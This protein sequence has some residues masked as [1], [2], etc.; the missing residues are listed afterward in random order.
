M[1]KKIFYGVFFLYFL[2]TGCAEN[3]GGE[4]Q[5]SLNEQPAQDAMQIVFEENILFDSALVSYFIDSAPKAIKQL[6]QCLKQPEIFHGL[7]PNRLLLYGPPG[8]G[9][10]TLAKV[11]AQEAGIYY[12]VI[13]GSSIATEYKNSGAMNLSRIF[14]T[15]CA[16]PANQ[17]IIV[18]IDEINYHIGKH[19]DSN[20]YDANT[21]P[22][23]WLIL[24]ECAKKYPNIFIIG[25]ANDIADMP[26]QLKSRFSH[27][28][29][30]LN[31]PNSIAQR[32]KIISFY[33]KNYIHSCSGNYINDLAE[34]TWG[35][36]PREL[37]NLVKKAYI[38]SLLRN[39]RVCCIRSS[40]C[41]AVLRS[42]IKNKKLFEKSSKIDYK[43]IIIKG[44]EYTGLCL[45]I[46][47]NM[48]L[49]T[50]SYLKIQILE[51][52]LS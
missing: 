14:S 45:G 4:L 30:P 48:Y 15:I 50:Q 52:Q 3:S 26:P 27:A 47:T 46:L 51:K 36:D 43:N 11:I 34:R 20:N 2:S 41:N 16:L 18:I 21:A 44:L 10:T 42:M 35:F 49:I 38:E 1:V 28:L 7:I 8:I 33:L 31:I 17:R 12:Y 32:R 24:D 5:P 29:V 13:E 25:T 37:E 19:N 22:T 9:K 40:D 6:V 39:A 23:L